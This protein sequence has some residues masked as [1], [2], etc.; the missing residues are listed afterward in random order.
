M[1]PLPKKLETKSNVTPLK[2]P[3]IRPEPP[4]PKIKK[5]KP[6]LYF[7]ALLFLYFVVL[8]SVQGFR[9]IHLNNEVKALEREIAAIKEENNALV[10]KIEMLND[11][12]YLEELARG[13]L[14]MIRKGDFIFTI[15]GAEK[16]P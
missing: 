4:V 16:Q 13:N 15:M 1:K 12:E 9:Y 3:G 8:F 14:G 7:F 5:K 10:K 2:R 6:A 11:P